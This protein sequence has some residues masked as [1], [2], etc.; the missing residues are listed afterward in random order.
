MLFQLNAVLVVKHIIVHL[1]IYFVIFILLGLW[2]P[3]QVFKQRSLVHL[4]S[5]FSIAVSLLCLFLGIFFNK[6]YEFNGLS[7]VVAN[8]LYILIIFTHFAIVCES[9]YR[10]K[11]QVSLIE[12]QSMIDGLILTKFGY[13]IPYQREKWKTFAHIMAL[14]SIQLII[15]MPYEFITYHFEISYKF[16]DFVRYSQFIVFARLIQMWFFV[17]LL[18]ARL[19]LVLQELIKIREEKELNPALLVYDKMLAIRQ[20]YGLL[21]DMCM[22]IET[23]FGWSMLM[24]VVYFFIRFTFNCYWAFVSLSHRNIIETFINLET[25]LSDFVTISMLSFYC[26][27]CYQKVSTN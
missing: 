9:I 20:I 27:S 17:Y 8:F 14:L 16:S 22:E 21:Y 5:L 25:L 12:K 6:L 7:N 18:R 15:R 11:I 19:K 1:R 3:H 10:H 4:F 24:T 13:Q 2:T 23:T 26:S